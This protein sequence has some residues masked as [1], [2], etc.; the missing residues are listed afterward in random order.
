[1]KGI[2]F[3]I[4]LCLATVPSIGLVLDRN[5]ITQLTVWWF[6]FGIMIAIIEFC[7][8][9]NQEYM[10]SNDCPIDDKTNWYTKEYP[11]SKMFSTRIWADGWKE[12]CK[13]SGDFRYLETMKG[14]FVPWIEFINGIIAVIFGIYITYGI[15]TRNLDS[16]MVALA[17]ISISSTQIF[18]T[19]VYF[20]SYYTKCFYKLKSMDLLWWIHLVVMNG[21]WMIFPAIVSIYAYSMLKT[22]DYIT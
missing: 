15:T 2:Y 7:M 5:L 22:G 11:L 6:T 18:G 9:M 19:I 1:M 21:L 12:Y 13:K 3:I 10:A 17:I 4:L 16:M 20:T 8:F 14:D